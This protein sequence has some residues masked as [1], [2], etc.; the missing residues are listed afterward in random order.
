VQ[1]H[2]IPSTSIPAPIGHIAI[3]VV[4]N[5]S[6]DDLL[7]WTAN[8]D[9]DRPAGIEVVDERRRCVIGAAQP[10]RCIGSARFR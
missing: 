9:P 6:V 7:R 8:A 2:R 3:G 5:T 10:T 1:H 4:E